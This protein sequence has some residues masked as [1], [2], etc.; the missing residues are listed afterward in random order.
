ML[1]F[2]CLL[3]KR[4]LCALRDRKWFLFAGIVPIVFLVAA[5]LIPLVDI[6][7]YAAEYQPEVPADAIKYAQCQANLETMPCAF[8]ANWFRQLPTV[9]FEDPARPGWYLHHEMNS[10]SHSGVLRMKQLDQDQTERAQHGYMFRPL[11]QAAFLYEFMHDTPQGSVYRFFTHSAN[12]RYA[13]QEEHNATVL[14]RDHGVSID[15][16]SPTHSLPVAP[17]K[18]MTPYSFLCPEPPY[19][20]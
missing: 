14:T 1:I 15:G 5:A 12:H 9:S 2:G 4:L 8:T 10:T 19:T 6:S 20:Y 18:A 7:S 11:D 3:K 13:F 16:L 17:Y